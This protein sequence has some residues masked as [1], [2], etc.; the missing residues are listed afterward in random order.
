MKNSGCSS[1]GASASSIP[2]ETSLRRNKRMASIIERE[3]DDVHDTVPKSESVLI[4]LRKK[5]DLEEKAADN[6]IEGQT[7]H[8]KVQK[9]H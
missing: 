5:R 9:V 7:C 3:N 6:E 8:I 4:Q 1:W 2:A